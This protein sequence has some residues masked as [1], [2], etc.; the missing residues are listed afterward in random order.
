MVLGGDA[1]LALVELELGSTVPGAAPLAAVELELLGSTE[2]ADPTTCAGVTGL[3]SQFKT[4]L[5]CSVLPGSVGSAFSAAQA[6]AQQNRSMSVLS[7]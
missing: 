4:E 7:L 2:P 5:G 1:T 3:R 6:A